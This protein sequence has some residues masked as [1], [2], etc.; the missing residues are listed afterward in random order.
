MG[1]ERV[2]YSSDQEY[3]Q[4]LNQE[5]AYYQEQQR[6]EENRDYGIEDVVGDFEVI[7]VTNKTLL[8]KLKEEEISKCT[9]CGLCKNRTNTV[10][11]RGEFKNPKVMF[12][13]E[14]PGKEEDELGK[15]FVG[16]AGVILETM[17]EEAFNFETKDS[18]YLTNILKCR[19]PEN[20][21]PNSEEI[22]SCLSYLEREIYVLQPDYIVCLGNTSAK[23]IF[24]LY[25][26]ENELKPISEIHGN[27]YTKKVCL[28]SASKNIIVPMYHPAAGLYHPELRSVMLADMQRLANEIAYQNLPF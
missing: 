13:G 22:K 27:S 9:R 19:P 24:T 10:C 6:K 11:G 16:S 20:R 12:V 18:Y 5:A 25:G 28:Q 8:E 7:D 17:I 21:T 3:Y 23:T 1:V 14:A 15:P 2:D 4:A 26:L